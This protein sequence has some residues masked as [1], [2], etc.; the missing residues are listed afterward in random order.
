MSNTAT[1]VKDNHILWL[2][3]PKKGSPAEWQPGYDYHLGDTVIPTSGVTIPSGF[4][5]YMFQC[6]AFIGK[7][8]GSQP[9]FPVVLGSSVIDNTIEW[10][11]R[12][13]DADPTKRSEEEYYIIKRNITVSNS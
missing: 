10:T 3:V 8:S 2:K 7:S 4:E 1:F 6:V 12:A 9:T 11:T 13:A 5:D